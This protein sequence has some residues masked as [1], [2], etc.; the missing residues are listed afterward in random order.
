[1]NSDEIMKDIP[2]FYKGKNIFIT[3]ASGFLGKV[4]MEKLL[5]S[6]QDVGKIYILLRPKHGKTFHERLAKFFDMLLFDRLKETNPEALN[7]IIPI[8][9]N[10][11]EVN[12]GLNEADRQLLINEVNIIF[13]AAA[14]VRFDD[15]LKDAIFLNTRCTR[16][17]VN[18]AKDMKN[19]TVLVHISTTYCHSDQ[20]EVLEEI[21]PPHAD[22]REAIDLAENY[23]SFTMDVLTKR[24]LGALPNTYTFTK[25][26]SERVISDLCTGQIP[27][28][29]VRPSIVIASTEEPI[30]GWIDNFNGPVGMILVG[31]T[32]ILRTMFSDP[33][34]QSDFVPVDAVVRVIIASAWQKG[35]FEEDKLKVNVLNCSNNRIMEVTIEQVHRLAYDLNKSMP[36]AN[37]IWYPT[38]NLTCK[39]Y[40]V[41][42]LKIIFYQWLPALLLDGLNKIIN[43]SDMSLMKINRKIYIANMALQYFMMHE[44]KFKNDNVLALDAKIPKSNKEEFG[45]YK[46]MVSVYNKKYLSNAFIVAKKSLLKETKTREECL[47]SANI[48]WLLS[49]IFNILWYIGIFWLL[50]YKFKVVDEI[51]SIGHDFKLYLLKL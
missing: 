17:V 45:K 33:D 46:Q 20:K 51:F 50:Y 42:H 2:E 29:I 47:R 36:I 21:Y 24:Y 44:W 9:G 1:M 22:W 16:D 31:G 4:L 13:H 34:V 3:G 7:K 26:L 5:R 15:P 38:D 41:Y 18:L 48:M 6:C 39:N 49:K 32:G 37:I 30:P 28:V 11:S 43:L 23:D 35:Q 14:S 19:L 12:L 25:A 8:N 40:Y 10:V 27:A